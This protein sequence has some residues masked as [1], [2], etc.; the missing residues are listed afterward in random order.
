VA[1]A[2]MQRFRQRAMEPAIHATNAP[3]N[4]RSLAL[5]ASAVVVEAALIAPVGFVVA[6]TL[7]FTLVARAFGSRRVAVDAAIGLALAAAVY[8]GFARGLG[9]SLPAGPFG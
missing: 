4:R 1:T 7:A 2:G 3:L 9:V 5:V 6:S 8:L